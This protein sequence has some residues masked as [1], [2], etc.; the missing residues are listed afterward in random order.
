MRNPLEKANSL[1]FEQLNKVVDWHELPREIALLNLRAFRDELRE[2][3][4]YD[5]APP[6]VES[7]GDDQ[8]VA[9]EELPPYRTY[10]GAMNDPAHPTMGQAGVVFGRNHPLG[11]TIPETLPE[12]LE[13][14]PRTVAR[15][16]LHRREFIPAT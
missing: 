10:D 5:G 13:P 16:L 3:N 1:F 4:L 9:I 14:N 8:P 7:K 12:L 11:V 2:A 15:E 6:S